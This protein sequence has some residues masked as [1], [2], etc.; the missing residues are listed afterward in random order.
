[1]RSTSFSRSSVWIS[2]PLPQTIMSGPSSAFNLRSAAG[3]SP[4]TTFVFTQSGSKGS[5]DTTYF[6][7]SLNGFAIALFGSC[8]GQKPAKML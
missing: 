6:V 5:C 1:M 3:T 8:F 7:A 2:V 4:E